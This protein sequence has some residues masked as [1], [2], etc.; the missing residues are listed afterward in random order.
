MFHLLGM[1]KMA[2]PD[3]YV[4]SSW[5]KVSAKAGYVRMSTL[6]RVFLLCLAPLI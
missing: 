5:D 1:I 2:T 3:R 4:M 6:H